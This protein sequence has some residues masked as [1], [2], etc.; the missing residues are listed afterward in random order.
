MYKISK[1]KLY[2]KHYPI[3]ILFF[4]LLVEADL[5]AFQA[6]KQLIYGDATYESS[7]KTIQ[8][9]PKGTNVQTRIS[10]AVQKF[11]ERSNLVL[12]FDDL[13][14]DADYY[15]V[16]FVHCN[17]DWTPSDLRDNMF[18]NRVNEFEIEEFEFSQES[19]I[20]YVHY[21]YLLPSFKVPGNYLAIVYRDRKKEDIIL[22]KQFMVY[23]NQVGLLGDIKLSSSVGNQQTNQ[24]IEVTLTYGDLKSLDP[25]KDFKIVVRQNQRF[26]N[27]IL[28]DPTFIN[29]NTQEIRYQNLGL[30]NDFSGGNEFRFFDLSTIN[31]RGRNIQNAGFENN[32]P[33]AQLAIDQK[34]SD[35]YFQTLDLNGQFYIR[36]LEGTG[37]YAT[38]AEYIK[39]VF[40][41]KTEKSNEEYFILGAFNLWKKNGTSRM[42]W[43]S[44][45]ELYETEYL[46]KQGWYDYKYISNKNSDFFERSF[47]ETENLYEVLVYFRPIG[48][49]GDQLIG[50]S[51]IDFNRRR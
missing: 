18:L 47:F 43:N 4:F 36:D 23:Q 26:D 16:R 7:I 30:D 8:L 41:L 37:N 2:L 42:K 39:T 10:P 38:T 14:D 50:Y 49:R 1:H 11:D 19:K 31:F 24:R 17:A 45:D 46:L 51:R 21:K 34:R 35:G 15:F 5:F 3:L 12:E 6:E 25:R 9:V 29:E 28:L 48:S 22:S 40:R 44:K 32:Q 33:F 27:S 13:R 20:P